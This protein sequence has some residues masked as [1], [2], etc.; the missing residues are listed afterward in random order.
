MK[1]YSLHLLRIVAWSFCLVFLAACSRNI[2]KIS[3]TPNETVGS[4]SLD[5]ADLMLSTKWIAKSIS[6]DTVNFSFN[7]RFS[8]LYTN[9]PYY[10]Q[11]VQWKVSQFYQLNEFQTYWLHDKAPDSMYYALI[12]VLKNSK[13]HGLHADEYNVA[14]IE[15]R[16]SSLY[17]GPA[18][19]PSE[20]VDLDIYL[21]E[22]CFL[23][24]TH[25][26]EGKIR[27][28][29]NG[30]NVWR[31]Y[32]K[33]YNVSDVEILHE[34]LHPD[35]LEDAIIKL[36]PANEQYARLQKALDHYRLLENSPL[37]YFP[38]IV[39]G[40]SIKPREKSIAIPLIRKKLSLMDLHVYALPFDT[41]TG[42]IDSLYYDET[43]VEGIRSFQ[44]RHGLEADGIIGDKT[45]RFLNQSAEYKAEIIA[46][47]MERLRWSPDSYGD[48]YV[49]INV[50]EYKLRVF[51]SQK[52][53]MEMRVIVGSV[54]K[55]TPIFTDVIKSIVFSPTWTVPVSII[56]EEIIPRL[57]QNPEYYSDKNYSF[58]KN[59]SETD[60]LQEDWNSEEINPY[61]FRVVQNPGPDNSLGLVKFTMSNDMSVYLH[62]TPN[63]RLFSKDYRA[64]SHGCVRLNEPGR[65]A[66]YLM[67]DHQG[68]DAMRINKKMNDG[69]PLTIRLKKSI[70]VHIEY[71]T[72]WVND[73][74]QINFREDIYGHDRVQLI[75]FRPVKKTSS[76]FLGM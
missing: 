9:D 4:N 11:K 20:V 47:N 19:S 25:L 51:E 42:S 44:T 35:Q 75:Q 12:A 17:N 22:M 49:F 43:L 28:L 59:E 40:E 14:K 24:T 56:R 65:F 71:R 37:L 54:S 8:T 6:I 38:N 18:V 36:Q 66:E 50:P 69:T 63:H 58:F 45:L 32:T 27:N 2:S 5:S 61:H 15:D 10:N 67:R 52:Q 64:L 23:F 48:N 3:K 21:S 1:L 55:P 68:W 33:E 70:P 39:S 73:D 62:D 30:K 74:G 53:V 72:A 7:S 34:I 76:T 16:V 41:I 29:K 31:R 57:K 26:M 60:P 46:L 13:Q